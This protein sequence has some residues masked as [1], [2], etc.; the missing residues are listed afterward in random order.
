MFLLL[1]GGVGDD[2]DNDDEQLLFAFKKEKIFLKIFLEAR[3]NVT[4][5]H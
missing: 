1:F 2:D 5:V 4:F 3:R